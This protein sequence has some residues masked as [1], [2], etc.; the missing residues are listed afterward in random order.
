MPALK[1]EIAVFITANVIIYLLLFVIILTISTA[2]NLSTDKKHDYFVSV[3]FS[4][5]HL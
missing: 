5:T 3:F 1:I 4:I 2:A